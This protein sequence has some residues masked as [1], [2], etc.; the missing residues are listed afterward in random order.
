MD[1]DCIGSRS[2]SFHLRPTQN[3]MIRSVIKHIYTFNINKIKKMIRSVI[4]HI[5]AFNINK[6]KKYSPIDV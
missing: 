2:L 1:F 6:I 3:Y 4:K 5:Y